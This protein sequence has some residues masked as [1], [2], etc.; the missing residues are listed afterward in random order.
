MG[1]SIYNLK[2]WTRMITGKSIL[3]V[4]QPIGKMY[5][6]TEIKGYYNDLT[7]KV[8]RGGLKEEELPKTEKPNG[9]SIEF[10]IA[11]F[12]YGLGAYDLFLLTNDEKY[13]KIFINVLNWTIENQKE[14]GGW[15]A[16]RDE[17]PQNP[18]SSMAQGEAISLLLRGYKCFGQKKYLEIATKA[19][20]FMIKSTRENGTTEY[21][22]NEVY[23]KEFPKSP[24]VLNGWIFSIFGLYDYLLVNPED[25]RIREIFNKTVDTLVKNLS[26]FD[27]NYWSKYDIEN[28]IASP[29]YHHLHIQLLYALYDLTM[30][31]ELKI[32]ADK[33]SEYEQNKL[34]KIK[35]FVIKAV[36]KIKER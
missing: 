31:E 21:K 12:Q 9:K 18:Y 30:R 36:Q 15:E 28:K 23:L 16:F 3:H 4:E 1:I 25:N 5:S 11:I 17:S 24:V 14:S 19:V 6:K 13:K 8:L 22:E 35:A 20:H 2:K 32:F 34:G 29:F 7:Q 27:L 26:K 33:C 10:P